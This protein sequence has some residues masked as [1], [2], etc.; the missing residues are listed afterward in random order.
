MVSSRLRRGIQVGLLL[1]VAGLVLWYWTRS[2]G[3]RRKLIVSGIGTV[4]IGYGIFI[5]IRDPSL[6]TIEQPVGG[7]VL[8]ASIAMVVVLFR[9]RIS[10]R[11][12][13]WDKLF[14][15]VAWA[16]DYCSDTGRPN[17]GC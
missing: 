11:C 14:L 9:N 13:T 3:L 2:V 17:S 4:G 16:L 7:G 8:V 12:C 6:E 1:F 10:G 15:W 5:S